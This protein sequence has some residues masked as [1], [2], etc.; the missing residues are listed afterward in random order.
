M[1][2]FVG[3]SYKN[4]KC[5]TVNKNYHQLIS[6]ER[7]KK[8]KLLSIISSNHV[9]TKEYKLRNDFITKLKNHFGNKI[10]VFGIGRKKVADKWDALA[11]YKYHIALEN[12]SYKDYWTEKLSDTFL[13]FC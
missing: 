7:P 8:N 13:S 4:G 1:P 3:K 10:D 9:F 12:S 2:W 6:L 11:P 5:I